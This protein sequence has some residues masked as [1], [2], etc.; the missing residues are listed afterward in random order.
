M[1]PRAWFTFLAPAVAAACLACTEPSSSTAPA[2]RPPGSA[3]SQPD[4]T[5]SAAPKPTGKPSAAECDALTKHL[6]DIAWTD[7]VA[8][9][10]DLRK[11]SPAEREVMRKAMKTEAFKDPEMKKMSADCR[12]E[13]DRRT[14]DCVMKAKNSKALDACSSE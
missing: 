5:G 12:K 7:Q 8:E 14:Y 13:F 2:S 4:A 11:A 1:C 10:P 3:S 6:V 9:D